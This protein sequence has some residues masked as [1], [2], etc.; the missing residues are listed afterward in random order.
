MSKLTD[1]CL[2]AYVYSQ[3]AFRGPTVLPVSNGVSAMLECPVTMRRGV[4]AAQLDSQ[5]L[6]VRNVRL[7]SIK[8][9]K[10]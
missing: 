7:S 9:I 1:V 2:H 5:G 3:P 8:S 4:V 6:A 10:I